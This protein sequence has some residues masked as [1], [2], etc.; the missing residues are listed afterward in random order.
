[1]FTDGTT[2]DLAA[3]LAR[4]YAGTPDADVT[5]GTSDANVI[6]G[7]AG[8]DTLYGRNGHD[9]LYGGADNDTLYG[10]D[11]NDALYGDM[12]QDSLDGGNGDDTLD[13]GGSSN[14]LNGGAGND[15]FIFTRTGGSQTIVENLNV[16]ND[17][18]TL[19]FDASIRFADLTGTKGPNTATI[20]MSD[21]SSANFGIGASTVAVERFLFLSDGQ[22]YTYAQLAPLFNSRPTGQ[23][24]IS[25]QAVQGATLSASHTLADA[26]GLGAISYTWL[27]NGESTGLTGNSYELSQNDVGA[28]ISVVASYTDGLGKAESVASAATTPVINVNDAP[29]GGVTITGTAI[30]GQT[31]TANHSLVDADGLGT[32]TYQWL[33]NGAATGT[34][35]EAYTL[36]Q[37]DVGSQITVQAMYTDGQGA[38]ESVYSA[39]TASVANVNDAPT[40]SLVIS[41]GAQEGQTLY[42][43]DSL[44]DADGLDP[45][46][47]SYQWLRN[48]TAVGV[49]GN[50]YTLT[51]SDV[52]ARI[53]VRAT[54]IDGQGTTESVTSAPTDAVLNVNNSP[55]GGLTISGSASQG[56]TLSVSH[57]LAD[58]DGLGAVAFRWLRNGVATSNNSASYL[59]GQADVGA[60]FTVVATYTDGQG[61]LESVT[62]AATS[63]VLNVNDAP[64]GTVNVTGTAIQGQTL[65]A[66]HNLA[67]ADGLGTVVFQWLRNGANTGTTGGTYVLSPADVGAKISVTAS[68]TDGQG[69]PEAVTSAQ[70]TAVQGLNQTLTGTTGSD[71]LTGGA[72]DDTLSGLG[73]NDTLYGGAGNDLLDGGTGTDSM[74]GGTGNDTYQVDA[75]TDVIKE[76]ANEGLDG[77]NSSVTY[78]LPANVENLTL[79]TT[80][81]ISGTGNALDNV[82]TGNSAAN[83]LTGGTGNDTLTGGA[84]NDT[85]V[86]GVGNDTYVID[87]STDVI[88]E[89][90]NEGTDTV[91]SPVTY[92]IA[93]LPNLEHITLTGSN[94]IN[95][96]GNAAANILTGN[97][98][99]NTLSGGTGIDTLIGGAGNDT[100][101]VD[102]LADVV[103]ESFNE[104]TDL[105]QSSVT[106]TL[107]ANVENLTLTT[108][109]AI[110]GT[111][112]DLDNL[113]TGNTGVN[114]LT[115]GLGND[116]L[117][118]GTGADSLVGGLGNDTYVVDNTTEK[119]TENAA[120]GTDLVK[121]GVSWTLAANFEHLTL[122]GSSTINGTGNAADNWLI[123]NGAI[124]T[125][126]GG[127]GN[128]T[129]DGGV[130]ADSL[131]GGAGNDIYFVDSTTEKLTENLNEGTDTVRSMV[132]W[133]LGANFEHL[134]LEGSN[135]I[136]GTG[137]TLSNALTGN[138]MANTLTG[139]GGNDTFR[140]GLGTDTLNSS[141]TTSN[142]TYIWGRGEGADALTDTGGVDQLQILAG[143][144]AD[145]VWL[146]QVGSNLEVSVIGTTDKFTVNN[147][148]T[149]TANQVESFKLA[150]GKT[151]T[152]GNVQKLVSAMA[153]FTVPAQG[154]TTLPASYQ[155]T[156]NPVIAANWT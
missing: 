64:T 30:Q 23:V 108:T 20:S 144:T 14:T 12:G 4:C 93:S 141:S 22:I 31:L 134:T 83:T 78:T 91:F 122:T 110:S 28:R 70:T 53:S 75:T 59:L 46:Q 40:G 52:G 26:D 11:G 47:V 54:Y 156:L 39:S 45:A 86:G 149:A 119:L 95:A 98:G 120:E 153:S 123:G 133:T 50:G 103:T 74:E 29:T 7:Q 66:S 71:T 68:Y 1:T 84:S 117:D 27:R 146:R 113:L 51:Q 19:V 127:L 42:V 138:A 61:T 58:V 139:A 79:I 72:G 145:Q 65:T 73:A 60:A 126:T 96:T 13:G 89:N 48:G 107:T 9:T 57:N 44:S 16:P 130:G 116:T 111:G 147:W 55:T 114:T 129:L 85:L 102:N 154:Q 90:A 137:N 82:L 34:L 148:Y 10:E 43:S 3:I 81:V 101:V 56:Q 152:S 15:T 151:L 25:G 37:A 87:V 49:N 135:A 132:T 94:T 131:V 140:G 99:A 35:G 109:S 100:Y 5:Y 67:D 88:T 150:D 76:L 106:Y 77:V 105:V 118:G 97:A 69:S 80:A 8:N 38:Q 143:V 32:I 36:T 24:M 155:T 62:S 128:D 115:G 104:G 112:N 18:D 124:N 125:L 2:W 92:S 21:G 63:A 121:A 41:G 136:N 6:S 142:D 33:R 17:V